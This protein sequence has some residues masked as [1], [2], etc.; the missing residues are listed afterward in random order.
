MDGKVFQKNRLIQARII[1]GYEKKDIENNCDITSS[2]LSQY[3][4]GKKEPKFETI[5]EIAKF[6]NTDVSFFYEPL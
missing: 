1:Q 3:E 4:K 5:K 2:A 6:L